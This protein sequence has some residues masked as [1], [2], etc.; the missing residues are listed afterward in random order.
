LAG[1]ICFACAACIGLSLV[2]VTGWPLLLL[3]VICIVS[4][5]TY[6][7][8]IAYKYSGIGS[9]LV[10][11][12]MGPLMVWGAYFA[13]TGRNNWDTILISLPVACLVFNI[14]HANDI[15]DIEHD[16][17]AHIK[18]LAI[19]VKSDFNYIL[20]E[21]MVAIPY[22]SVAL[23][24]AGG[25]LSPFGLLIFMTLPWGVKQIR[26]AERARHKNGDNR[27]TLEAASAKFH[28]R[29]GVVYFAAILL[30]LPVQL[31]LNA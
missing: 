1:I 28:L 11:F 14:L 19:F 10:F 2:L 7:A 25:I 13:Q 5:Y 15:R 3:G 16:K 6:T 23:L 27:V 9:L 20:Y 29:F 24:V 22:A 31:L 18:T 12:L 17:S 8:G 4:G 30:A 26:H 21:I